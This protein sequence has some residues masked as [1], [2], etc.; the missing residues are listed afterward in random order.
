MRSKKNFM[1]KVVCLYSKMSPTKSIAYLQGRKKKLVAYTQDLE[2][3]SV[4]YRQDI[5]KKLVAYTL[6]SQ[7]YIP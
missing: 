1:K 7:A 4:A 5:Q 6:S 2:K 3:K